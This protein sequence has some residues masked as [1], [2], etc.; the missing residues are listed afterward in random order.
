MHYVALTKGE[1]RQVEINEVAPGQ[2]QLVMGDRTLTV[3]SRV[4]S[5]TTQSLLHGVESYNIEAERNP[6]GG[7]NVLVRGHI[8]SVEVLDL[9]TLRLRQAQAVLAGPDGPVSITAPMP[10]KVVAVLVVEGQ[11][12]TEGQGLLVVEAMKME[13]EL[14][15]PRAGKV[16]NLKIEAGAAV[17]GGVALC[18]IE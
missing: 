2:F 10:G 6:D 9:R 8:V 3:D 5:E 1:E 7:E 14:K 17:E 11:E 13:N 18:V 12:V 16:K 15:S 4:V